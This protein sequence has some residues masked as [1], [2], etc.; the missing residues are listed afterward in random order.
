MALAF[1]LAAGCEQK[2]ARQ[3]SYRPY[4]ASTFF[5]DDRSARPLEEGTVARGYLRDNQALYY[6]TEGPV[7]APEIGGLA[8]WLLSTASGGRYGGSYVDR[9]PFP[10]TKQVL[11]EGQVKF[12]VYC[13]VC[14][15]RV[16]KGRGRIVQRG[17]LRPPSYHTDR[18]RDA[19]VGY[20]FSVITNGHGAMPDYA[21][22]IPPQDRWAIV[23][24]VKALQLSQNIRYG[25]LSAE[26]RAR[27]PKEEAP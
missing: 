18:L 8:G 12:N 2:M 14:H 27:L 17:Y 1:L 7:A 23:A 22:Q 24:Y 9:F 16:G 3:P 20:I 15:D 11:D 25:D 5:G 13:A 19:P 10:I 6:G 26:E 4:T 21:A